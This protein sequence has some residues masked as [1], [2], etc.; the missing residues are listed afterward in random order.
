MFSIS[1]AAAGGGELP[2]FPTCD[3]FEISLTP[4][5]NIVGLAAVQ[6]AKAMGANV[7]AT[8]GSKAKLEVC[9]RYGADHLVDYTKEGWQ[10]EVQKITDGH[11]ADM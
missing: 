5:V 7:I 2:H 4:L 11:G 10:K 3:S 6:I 8:A 9:K 1:Q